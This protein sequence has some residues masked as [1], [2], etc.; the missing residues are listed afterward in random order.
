MFIIKT[1]LAPSVNE[2]EPVIKQVHRPARFMTEVEDGEDTSQDAADLVSSHDEVKIQDHE[3]T[4]LPQ[5]QQQRSENPAAEPI[6]DHFETKEVTDPPKPLTV[7]KH[8]RTDEV[9]APKNTNIGPTPEVAKKE[10]VQ[11]GKRSIAVSAQS[12]GPKLN[13]NQKLNDEDENFMIES[14]NVDENLYSSES[15]TT[16]STRS[17]T[18]ST[19]PGAAKKPAPVQPKLKFSSTSS[20]IDA[21]VK[22]K[23]TLPEPSKIGPPAIKP[24]NQTKS[25]VHLDSDSDSPPPVR[26][27]GGVAAIKFSPRGPVEDLEISG[28]ENELDDDDFW[29]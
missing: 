16:T 14:D 23:P 19:D 17:T 25:I 21:P 5:L 8:A 22:T 28:P 6:V 7:Q 24:E 11:A 26:R 3:K 9:V 20:S 2:R 4:L 29:N 13:N 10:E 27:S 18:T 12:Q 1:H 15:E